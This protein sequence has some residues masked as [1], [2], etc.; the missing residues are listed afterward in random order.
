MSLAEAFAPAEAHF[1]SKVM[2]ATW[3]HLFPSGFYY[4]GTIRVANSCYGGTA[5]LSEKIEIEG[6]PWWYDAIHDFIFKLDDIEVGEVHAVDIAVKIVAL[7]DEDED[8]KSFETGEFEFQ[9]TKV[10]SK[11]LV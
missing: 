7:E 1:K 3:G 2:H 6:S 5:I 4:E 8:G 10:R 9:I 11:K